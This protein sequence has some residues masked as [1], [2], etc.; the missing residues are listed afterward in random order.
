MYVKENFEQ[1]ACR[2][3]SRNGNYLSA[4]DH[5]NKETPA[6]LGRPRCRIDKPDKGFDFY[7]NRNR[8]F[9]LKTPAGVPQVGEIAARR[10]CEHLFRFVKP[11]GREVVEI[12]AA[13]AAYDAGGSRLS[14]R[15]LEPLFCGGL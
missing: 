7:S 10:S 12:L 6:Q 14:R 3:L 5:R 1:F 2:P 11:I 15:D 13:F 8:T 9:A 4:G